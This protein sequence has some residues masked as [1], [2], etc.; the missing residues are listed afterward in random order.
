[1]HSSGF[2]LAV[3]KIQDAREQDLIKSEKR[4]VRLLLIEQSAAA[5]ADPALDIV[6]ERAI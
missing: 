3:V 4:A 6:V 1:M 2:E 5:E